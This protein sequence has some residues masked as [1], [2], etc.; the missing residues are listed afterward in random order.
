MKKLIYLFLKN[1]KRFFIFICILI[2]IFFITKIIHLYTETNIPLKNI[3]NLRINLDILKL[4]KV[5]HGSGGFKGK[6]YTNSLESLEFNKFYFNFFEI[7]FYLNNQNRLICSHNSEDAILSIDELMNKYEYTPCTLKSLNEWLKNNPNKFIITDV[8]DN[9]YEALILIKNFIDN[10]E[11]KIIPQIYFYEEYE[12]VK[13]LGFKKIIWTF[14]RL[15]D[16]QK[17]L[18]T[19][20]K[21]LE[22]MDLYSVT[23]G[24]DLALLGYGNIISKQNLPIYLHTINSNKRFL[25]YKFFLGIDNIYTDWLH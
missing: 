2:F 3:I 9:N 20:Q 23:I 24:Q 6:T 16:K 18:K 7:D 14:Y 15:N 19:I 12:K 4:E 13:K 10:Y 1:K 8:K 25:F 22:N 17:D 21:Q 5:A 11:D